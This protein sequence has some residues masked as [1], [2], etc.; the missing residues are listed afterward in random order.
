M[1]T[2]N[3]SIKFFYGDSS[4]Y[5]P[6]SVDNDALYLIKNSG[7]YA[8]SNIIIDKSLFPIN[9]SNTFL[10]KVHCNSSGNFE[11]NATGAELNDAINTNKTIIGEFDYSTISNLSTQSPD[12]G[13]AIPNGILLCNISYSELMETGSTIKTYNIKLYN[14]RCQFNISLNERTNAVSITGE[15]ADQWAIPGHDHDTRYNGI[16]SSGNYANTSIYVVKTA[17]A[18]AAK[19]VTVTGW[20]ANNGNML[21][22]KFINGNTAANPTLK[23]NNEGTAYP[24]WYNSSATIDSTLIQ[25][26]DRVT[27]VL[28]SDKLHIIS[29]S[30]AIGRIKAQE[31]TTNGGNVLFA[32]GTD[33]Q[34]PMYSPNLTVTDNGVLDA[35]GLKIRGDSLDQLFSTNI[36]THTNASMGQAFGTCSTAA[37]TAEKTVSIDGFQLENGAIIP[38]YFSYTN[39]ATSPTLNINN[40][41]AK[42]IYYNNAAIADRNADQVHSGVMTFMYDGTNYRIISEY[43]TDA[44]VTVLST[45]TN[46]AYPVLFKYSANN[47]GETNSIRYDSTGTT[48]FNY[49]PNTNTLTATNIVSNSISLNDIILQGVSLVDTYAKKNSP[50]FTGTPT[51]P[52]AAAGTNTT[53]I[54]TTE[55]VQTAVSNALKYTIKTPSNYV[56]SFTSSSKMEPN[57]VY[58]V[59]SMD[60]GGFFNFSSINSL[61]FASSSLNNDI[62]IN[63]NTYQASIVNNDIAPTYQILFRASSTFSSITLPSTVK[64]KDRL[65]PASSDIQGKMCE[66][67]IMNDIATINIV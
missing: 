12:T 56:V 63:W 40:T 48:N 29:I 16:W 53:Q 36:H 43:N 28:W 44:K 35:K 54:A 24:I 60:S 22:L 26:G 19:T 38:I 11:M 49:N 17:A 10:V 41:G 31:E 25:A 5:P 15:I 18:T 42:A 2:S 67:T 39:T 62:S 9:D 1:P 51:A 27:L 57:T 45:T 64:W 4:L 30:S 50:A 47:T 59:G 52:T 37:A 8:G 21:E 14:E 58:I 46:S 3:N 13:I 6:Q 7:V 55:F 65:A 20:R 66:L 61:S 32:H 23:I 33:Y 34:N